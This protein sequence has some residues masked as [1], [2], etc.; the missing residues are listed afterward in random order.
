MSEVAGPAQLSAST[1]P[2]DNSAFALGERLQVDQ[3]KNI[4][5]FLVRYVILELVAIASASYLT[6]LIY[7]EAP[8]AGW[9]AGRAYVVSAF[10]L[11]AGVL[12]ISLGLKHFAAFQ[13]Q[14][15]HRVLWNAA[16]AVTIAFSLFLSGLFLLKVA[17][18]YSRGTFLL[19][20][21]VVSATALG[22]RA[23]AHARTRAAIAND[24]AEAR[25]AIVF[26]SQEASESVAKSLAEA[27][28]RIV[29]SSPIPD[30]AL[31]IGG[32]ISRAAQRRII[33][34]CRATGVRRRRHHDEGQR[35]AEVGPSCGFPLRTSR[36][37]SPSG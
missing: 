18:D 10:L 9:T 6:S 7:G 33:E 35:P 5:V 4:R 16:T 20:L 8:W 24:R 13:L 31:A 19:Q 23:L 12:S 37:R 15:V 25:R 22:V 28:I 34:T 32:E 36:F 29:C 17:T 1:F 30:N 26:G 27:G 3:R 2:A 14:P 11:A 21:V